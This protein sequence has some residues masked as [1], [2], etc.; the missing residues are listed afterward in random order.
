MLSMDVNYYMNYI[1]TEKLYT[2]TEIGS[3]LGISGCM[4][5]KIANRLNLK[6][7]NLL[8]INNF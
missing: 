8:I 6:I 4:V 3:I 5:G 1:G 2:A 7:E